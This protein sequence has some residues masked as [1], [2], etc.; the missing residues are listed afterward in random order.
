MASNLAYDELLAAF[1]WLLAA[2]RV[3]RLI[4]RLS[5]GPREVVE[6]NMKKKKMTQGW[7]VNGE[8]PR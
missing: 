3:L 6:C 5:T 8:S 4:K 2:L 1:C 7:V